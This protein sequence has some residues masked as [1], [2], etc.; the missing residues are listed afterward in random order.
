MN[1]ATP[2]PAPSPLR[3]FWLQLKRD[4]K[5]AYRN[6]AAL[7]N[8]LLFFVMVVSLFPFGVGPEPSTLGKIAP[9][10]LWVAALL[11]TL[12]ALDHLFQ[13]DFDDGSLEQMLLSPHPLS[14]L[15]L[16]KTLAHWL[17]TGLPLIAASP[18]LALLLH[19]PNAA[20]TTLLASLALG[21]PALSLIG[22]IGAALTVSIRRSGLLLSLLVMPLYIP[23]LIFGA[24]SVQAASI[25]LSPAG[26]LYILA[27]ALVLTLTLA[28]LAIAAALRISLN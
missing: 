13:S 27:T 23:V 12:L 10:V 28:P 15:A 18:L 21:T 25:G 20:Y 5:L 6:R 19:L 2:V 14:L 1:A 3:I 4:L 22:G 7:A 16:S 8:P 17:T 9:G 11:A 26:H 24:S